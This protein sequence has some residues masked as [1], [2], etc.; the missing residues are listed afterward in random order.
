MKTRE[1]SISELGADSQKLI[2]NLIGREEPIC[3]YETRETG[4]L[5]YYF[6]IVVTNTEIIELRDP[7]KSRFKIMHLN[8]V[9]K[10]IGNEDSNMSPH[11]KIFGAGEKCEFTFLFESNEMLFAFTQKLRKAVASTQKVA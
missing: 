11:I 4:I 10:I 6:A 8:K 5:G 7:S 3:C 2:S 1:C 9:E